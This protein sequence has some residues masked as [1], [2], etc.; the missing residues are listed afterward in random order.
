MAA[1][2]SINFANEQ[3]VYLDNPPEKKS[4]SAKLLSD[5]LGG[6]V[7]SG[8]YVRKTG[9][10][11]TGYLT[12][13]S[14]PP[15]EPFHAVPKQYVDDHSY[16]RRYFYECKDANQIG[17][18]KPGTRV[19]SGFD[20]Y[21]NLLKFFDKGT[22][23]LNSISKYMDV[24]RNGILQVYGQD[25]KI[26]NTSNMFSGTTAIEFFEP[27]Q[28]GATF[29]VSIGNVG[30]FPTTFGV[31]NIYGSEFGGFGIRTTA[32]SGD[33]TL[34]VTPTS[35][36]ASEQQVFEAT[37]HDR[38]LTPRS[39]SGAKLVNKAWGLFRKDPGY[40]RSTDGNPENPYGSSRTSPFPGTFL[41]AV[42]SNIHMIRN[43]GAFETPR[44]MNKFRVFIKENILPSTDYVTNV[45]ANT[46]DSFNPDDAVLINV[47]GTTR[48]LT[49][50]D[51]F[52][53][54]MFTS[55]PLDIY[56]FN[57]NIT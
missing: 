13:T 24:Y 4:V 20:L 21:T 31:W 40:D 23:S 10:N 3:E 37:V 55:N 5:V 22:G 39:L 56:E 38:F 46:N 16:T 49:S 45:T 1:T 35:F 44:A 9:D 11:M 53:Y 36:V 29:Q 57:V 6:G 50:F 48:T 42:S 51:F 32:T 28:P 25:Y 33:V 7:V 34:F 41:P 14:I 2:I 12:L 52:V 15:K 18:F 27:F 47:V 43:V 54:D 19:L 17:C 30:A 26:I 8:G